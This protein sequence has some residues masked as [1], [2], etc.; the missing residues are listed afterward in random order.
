MTNENEKVAKHN[1]YF[2]ISF[3]IQKTNNL[4]N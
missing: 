3:K 4:L 2:G 1:K